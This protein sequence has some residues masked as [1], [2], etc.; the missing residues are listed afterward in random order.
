MVGL[1][2]SRAQGALAS[3]QAVRRE[4]EAANIEL[5]ALRAAL[6]RV[7]YGI[8]LLDHELRAQFINGSFR[9]MWRLPDEAAERKPAFVGLMYHGRDTGAYAV[10]A[11]EMDAYVAQRTAS[12]RA[13]DEQPRDVRLSNGDV[14]CV[15]CKVLPDGG[16]MLT[17][18]NVTDRVKRAGDL[19]QLATHDGMTGLY[20]R[21]HF[22][23]LAD[24]E[25]ARFV[26]YQRPLSVLTFDIDHFK[27]VNDRYG[28]GAGDKVI[29]Q[30]AN[31]CRGSK[32]SSDIVARV[33]G[34]EFVML[35]PE[36]DLRDA[37]V[38]AERLR[39][40]VPQ[41]PLLIDGQS[42]PVTVSI[43]VATAGAEMNRFGDLLDKADQALYQAKRGGRDRI[44]V[45]G[46]ARGRPATAA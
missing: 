2:Q 17:Y 42:L 7:D 45:A 26:R 33:G 11:D 29:A 31:V 22:L 39:K 35:L 38:V 12:V 32:R 25:W 46:E 9:R 27:A 36:T 15:R 34:E 18:A 43:G 14:V 28:H 4:I 1:L 19:E 21:S 3:E 23:E 24:G 8:V 37:L 44:C 10:R 16:R 6:D 13:G 20:N 5:M 30:I 41:R 40:E